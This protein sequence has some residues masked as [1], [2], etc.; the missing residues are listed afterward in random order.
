MRI[1]RL[2]IMLLAA[3]FAA[4]AA[5]AAQLTRD[6]ALKA[7]EQPEASARLPAV[8]RLGDIGEMPDADRL[9][10]RLVDRDPHVRA[11][12]NDAIWKIW[13]RS[14]DSDIDKL[15]SNGL[16]QMQES[17]FEDALATF[18]TII[19]RKPDFAEGWNKRATIY[20]VLGQNEKSLKDCDEVLK[21]NPNH[22]G[23]LSG[24][25]QIELRL[26]N[27]DLAL[28]YFRR[29]VEVNPNLDGA[30]ALIPLIE[31]YLREKGRSTT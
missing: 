1:P 8:E 28:E 24:A 2:W 14:G 26:G 31:K 23:A 7:L 22:Y 29:A 15:F 3:F 16:E 18:S 11:A 21:R 6:Q 9:L 30:A 17:K 12:A 20:F 4:T 10:S 27:P 13:S 19:A 25:G 5:Y